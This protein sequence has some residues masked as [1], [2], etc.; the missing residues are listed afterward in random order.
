MTTYEEGGSVRNEIG[1]EVRDPVRVT[2]D[3]VPF[4]VTC[5]TETPTGGASPSSS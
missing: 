1:V 5:E 2:S 3:S 4:S